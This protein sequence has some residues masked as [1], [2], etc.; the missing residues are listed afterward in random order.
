MPIREKLIRR[1]KDAPF[2]AI[3][4]GEIQ[5]EKADGKTV[6]DLHD[7]A[8][9]CA[10]VFDDL[11]ARGGLLSAEQMEKL[12]ELPAADCDVQI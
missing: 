7:E 3:P 10:P 1:K 9:A 12:F 8:K 2:A 4:R 6:P 11:D 5:G